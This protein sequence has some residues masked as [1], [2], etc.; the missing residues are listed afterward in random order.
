M[1][2]T[3]TVTLIDGVRVV[4]PDTLD[5]ITPYVLLEQQDW[6]EDE[7][8]FLRRLLKPGQ[9]VIDIGANCGVYAL[10]MAR[11]VGQV[12]HVWAFEPASSAADL[13]A[14]GIAANG[15]AQVTLERSALS[16]V[17]G[18]AQLSLQ[19][20]SE[21]NALVRGKPAGATETVPV[22]TLDDCLETRDW[23]DIEFVKIDAEGEEANILH[24]G[25]RFFG[26]QSPLVQYEIKA[27]TSLQLDVVQAFAKLGYRSYRLVPVLDL[28]VPFDAGARPDGFLLNLFCCKPDRAARLAAQGFLVE[29]PAR[30][31]SKGHGWRKTVG[32]LPYGKSLAAQW[33]ETVAAGDSDTVEEALSLYAL[34][35][36]T[37]RPTAERLG[38]LEAS[39]SRLQAVCE[40][41]P[42]YLRLSS[43]ARVARDYGARELAAGTLA[44]LCRFLVERGPAD[45]G[46]PFLAP[47]ER[48]DT[49]PPGDGFGNWILAGALEA[50]ELAGSYSSFYTGTGARQRLEVIRDLGYGS[51]EMRRRL[52]LVQRRFGLPAS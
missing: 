18:T 34:S 47:V 21:L 11:A 38:A 48:F 19:E 32:T 27:D 42:A 45:P 44:Q 31:R 35:R 6:F 30:A 29:S 25:A 43:L 20:H 13:L 10:T 9:R 37:S 17:K 7:I 52:R 4:V 23:R 8:K 39:L 49:V 15:Y 5:L 14:A 24:G 1:H 26:R 50:L 2:P 40:G 16:G 28:L 36:D 22:L 41:E 12:G 51:A 33:D 46:E 3:T